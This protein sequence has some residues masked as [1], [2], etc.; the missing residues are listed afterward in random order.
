[1]KLGTQ[2]W[3]VIT[4]VVVI[5]LVAGGWFLGASP[6]LDAKGKSD[7]SRAEIAVQ[8]DV[9]AAQIDALQE[10]KADLPQLEARAAELEDA[11]PGEVGGAVFIRSLNDLATASGVTLTSI[12]ISDGTAYEAP[13]EG[14][15]IEGA[16]V[17]MTNALITGE[18][19]VLVPVT[20]AVEGGWSELLAFVHA[21]QTGKRLVLVTSLAS[22]GGEEG[23]YQFQLGGTM[24]ALQR[25]G[26]PRIDT[27][28]VAG[29]DAAEAPP[30]G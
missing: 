22:S 2:I 11:I 3:S 15:D 12:T 10:K 23:S 20:I 18:N 1:V 26:A 8:N 13:P 5:A 17:P 16:P 28:G 7:T 29:G 14:E 27:S 25:P 9:L 21:V 24:Y 4:A 30:Q 19:F 6:L